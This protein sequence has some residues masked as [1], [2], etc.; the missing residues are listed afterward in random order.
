MIDKITQGNS[1]KKL[2]KDLNNRKLTNCLLMN[3]NNFSDINEA[4]GIRVG[5]A[6]LREILKNLKRITQDTSTIYHYYADNFVLLDD[7]FLKKTELVEIATTIL[8]YF[9]EMEMEIDEDLSFGITFSIGISTN[10]G[11]VNLSQAELAINEL[12]EN[13][14]NGYNFFNPYSKFVYKKQKDIYWV[15][16]IQESIKKGDILVYYQ[17]IIDNRTNKVVKY[18][19]LIRLKDGKEIIS[20]HVFLEAAEKIAVLPAM[21]RFLIN[22]AINEIK[23]K[24]VEISINITKSDLLDEYLEDYLIKKTKKYN[25][26]IKRITLEILEDIGSLGSEILM[27]QLNRLRKQGFKIAMDDFGAENANLYKLLEFKPDILKIDGVFIKDIAT[28]K[29]SRIITEAIVNICKQTDILIIAEYIHNKETLDIIKELGIEYSQG[30]YFSE[31]T[32]NIDISKVKNIQT[33]LNNQ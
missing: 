28:D 25:V 32:K 6:V 2:F 17:P 31:P 8:N 24:N 11:V 27:N 30:Y 9:N 3:I 10:I 13:N 1:S 14:R 15:H 18:E 21:T 12:R 16:K 29:K 23:D 7:R 33:T 19:C 5:N 20:P 4:F 22:E 26:D